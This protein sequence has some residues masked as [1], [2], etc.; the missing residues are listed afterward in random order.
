MNRDYNAEFKDN[1][2]RKYHYEFDTFA[3]EKLLRRLRPFFQEGNALEVGAF[4]GVMTNRLADEFSSLTVVEASSMLADR[5][6]ANFPSVTVVN[7][8]VEDWVTNETFSNIFIV[9]TLEHIENRHE[10]LVSLRQ[11]LAP[12]G[13][14]FVAVPNGNALSRQIA[15]EMGLVRSTT[16]ITPGERSH[17]HTVTFTSESLSHELRQAGFNIVNRGGVVVKSLSNGQIDA[18][19]SAGIISKEYLEASDRLSFIYPELSSSIYVVVN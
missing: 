4:E 16:S 2:E 15:V 10:V 5:L 7:T 18:A 12:G 19:M 3:R 1:E 13:N 9:H 11:R 14:M 6:G 8:R 17:G